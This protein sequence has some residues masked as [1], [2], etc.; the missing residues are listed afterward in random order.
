MGYFDFNFHTCRDIKS[1]DRSSLVLDIYSNMVSQN[2]PNGHVIA[3]QVPCE[4]LMLVVH[5]HILGLF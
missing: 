3:D 4:Q 2:F 5:G 1:K